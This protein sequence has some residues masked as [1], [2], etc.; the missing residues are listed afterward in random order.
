[1]IDSEAKTADLAY[2]HPLK[3]DD[4]KSLYINSL[5]Y[6]KYADNEEALQDF[7]NE[8]HSCVLTMGT[9]AMRGIDTAC[10][11]QVYVIF[12]FIPEQLSDV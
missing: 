4:N 8:A 6:S 1:M 7:E 10:Q 5:E 11:K 9:D 2:Q 12:A 3:G